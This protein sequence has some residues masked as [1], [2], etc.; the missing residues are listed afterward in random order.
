MAGRFEYAQAEE[1]RDA[2]AGH[3]VRYLFLGKSGT[4]D[5]FSYVWY[6]D[7]GAD[8]VY[9]FVSGGIAGFDHRMESVI[10]FPG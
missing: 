5:M 10:H 4:A 1:I 9:T 7:D 6:F 3:G 2:F 8:T